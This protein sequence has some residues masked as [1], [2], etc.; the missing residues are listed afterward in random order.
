M[1]ELAEY[2]NTID[3]WINSLSKRYNKVKAIIPAS[4]AQEKHR[5]AQLE[6]LAEKIALLG[7]VKRQ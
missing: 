5:N 3:E 4:K 6:K 2:K 1:K 7:I